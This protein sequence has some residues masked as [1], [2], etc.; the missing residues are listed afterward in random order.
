METAGLDGF[1]EALV[2]KQYWAIRET[3]SRTT[4]KAEKPGKAGSGEVKWGWGG[5]GGDR[6]QSGER[7]HLH[8]GV[9][10]CRSE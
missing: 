7:L 2:N 10:A 6:Q 1:M 9:K 3:N 8:Q 5:G 4:E